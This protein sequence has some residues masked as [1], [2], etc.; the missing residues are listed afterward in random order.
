M[1][2]PGAAG[3]LIPN[4]RSLPLRL[5]AS[6]SGSWQRAAHLSFG[7][8]R[9]GSRGRGIRLMKLDIATAAGRSRGTQ[10]ARRLV[11][12]ITQPDP[13]PV[14]AT[15][16]AVVLH[17]DPEP[18]GLA[19]VEHA[20]PT[21]ITRVRKRRVHKVPRDISASQ[22]TGRVGAVVENIHVPPELAMLASAVGTKIDELSR[23]ADDPPA[24]GYEVARR[25]N[26][27]GR[28]SCRER[29]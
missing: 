6:G 11:I 1:S 2:P 7:G 14:A 29:V 5:L 9:R 18:H 22:V 27:I 21:D 24:A 23:V 20:C 16:F 28:A 10:F 3:Q 15:G 26:E 17:P 25:R 4:N 8:R 19:V 12:S 13:E